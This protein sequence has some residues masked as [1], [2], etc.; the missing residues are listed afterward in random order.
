MTAPLRL[1]NAIDGFTGQWWP[2]SNYYVWPIIVDGT[3]YASSE[4]YYQSAKATTEDD[5]AWI[6]A[7]AT[8]DESK[9]RARTVQRR[10]DWDTTRLAVM[11]RA[12]AAKFLPDN[13]PG[14]VL[15][16]TGTAT[17]LESNDW[18]DD[19]WG[20][21]DGAGANLLGVLLMERRGVIRP[22]EPE[23][24]QWNRRSA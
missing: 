11:R 17:L 15:L 16:A 20:V 21:C 5:W 19:D 3:T 13:H 18:G 8:P 9:Q 2:L 12:L 6:R 4:H 10:P 22:L 14:S 7:A 1:V 23:P 24:R